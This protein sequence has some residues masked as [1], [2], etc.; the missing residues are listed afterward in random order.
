MKKSSWLMWQRLKMLTLQS[1]RLGLVRSATR[2]MDKK[3]L[4]AYLHLAIIVLAAIGG[5]IAGSYNA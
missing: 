5:Y 4:I 2:S 1:M 3:D